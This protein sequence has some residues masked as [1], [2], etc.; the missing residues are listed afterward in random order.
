MHKSVV[1]AGTRGYMQQA[2]LQD[3][4]RLLRKRTRGGKYGKRSHA[5]VTRRLFSSVQRVS[6]FLRPPHP[7]SS[8]LTLI[9]NHHGIVQ[10]HLT[11]QFTS[12]HSPLSVLSHHNLP[13]STS[14]V[15]LYRFND[16]SFAMSQSPRA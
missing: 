6:N 13:L 7:S 3:Q 2:C 5:F 8:S 9:T 15:C 10:Q 1:R 12:Y 11:P 16:L 14:A 4:S